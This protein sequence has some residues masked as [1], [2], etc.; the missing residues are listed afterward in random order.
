MAKEASKISEETK[1][2]WLEE[3]LG[4][5]GYGKDILV[6]DPRLVTLTESEIMKKGTAYQARL[7]QRRAFELGF[8]PFDLTE[9]Q[10]TAVWLCLSFEELQPIYRK[11]AVGQKNLR[12][13]KKLSN[14]EKREVREYCCLT[15][16]IAGLK[17]P[18]YDPFMSEV[19]RMGKKQRALRV[20]LYFL[21]MYHHCEIV[22][23]K[24]FYFSRKRNGQAPRRLD[25]QEYV[26]MK[27]LWER[28]LK[29]R[30]WEQE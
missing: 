11:D 26:P 3:A 24:L 6:L 8:N 25:V 22:F 30:W 16:L 17:P 12:L 14:S 18:L 13:Q 1:K 19:K 4:H 27:E 5:P 28:W 23:E 10:V 29:R 15:Y 9:E 7:I 20:L 21:T 2:R